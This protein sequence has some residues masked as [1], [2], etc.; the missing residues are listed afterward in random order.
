MEN[1]S[2]YSLETSLLPHKVNSQKKEDYPVDH[3]TPEPEV[4]AWSS[5]ILPW[6]FWFVVVAGSELKVLNFDRFIDNVA[7]IE[8]ECT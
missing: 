1:P 3:D 7:S 4:F 2:I 8:F 5:V 6:V